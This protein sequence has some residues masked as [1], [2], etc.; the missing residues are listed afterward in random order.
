MKKIFGTLQIILLLCLMTSIVYAT[1]SIENYD[2]KTP[3][4][5]PYVVT[6]QTRK[7]VDYYK[8]YQA[9][10]KIG[11]NTPL[12]IT[13]EAII[14]GV[15]YSFFRLMGD[16][17]QSEFCVLSSTVVLV[18]DEE[19]YPTNLDALTPFS[20]KVVAKDGVILRE[21]PGNVYK[22]VTTIPV[23]TNLTVYRDGAYIGPWLYTTYN[24]KSGW[25][26]EINGAIGRAPDTHHRIMA[27]NTINIYEK[28]YSDAVVRTVPAST[29]ITSFLYIDEWSGMYYVD[30][31][32]VTGYVKP[33]DCAWSRLA[34]GTN[35][36]NVEFGSTKLYETASVYSNVLVEEI[37][38][39]TTLSYEYATDVNE[40]GWIYTKYGGVTGWAHI[41]SSEEAYNQNL[42]LLEEIEKNQSQNNSN[43]TNENEQNGGETN[44]TSGEENANNNNNNNQNG[45]ANQNDPNSSSENNNTTNTENNENN[46]GSSSQNTNNTNQ[47]NNH[48]PFEFTGV[49]FAILITSIIIVVVLTSAVTVMIMKKK[50]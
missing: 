16:E 13:R 49:Q 43:N 35:K 23:G 30:F 27:A 15:E 32:G 38:E 44:T 29:Q 7:G 28:T 33:E 5:T 41:F 8:N 18:N 21:G 31:R 25:I 12:E 22:R 45:S 20:V 14:D 11:Q 9:I 40:D 19:I 6:A 3:E 36:K 17:R 50:R 24:G 4:I 47:S 10:G 34:E 37:P 1:N 26:C 42:E 2:I 46:N 39:G 48:N